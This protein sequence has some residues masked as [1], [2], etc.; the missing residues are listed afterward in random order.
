MT[1]DLTIEEFI[2]EVPSLEEEDEVEAVE[3]KTAGEVYGEKARNPDKVVVVV[4]TKKGARMALGLPKGTE[5]RDGIFVIVD[6]IAAA[7]SLKNQN[8]KMVQWIRKYGKAPHVGQKV[9]VTVNEAGF[10]DIVL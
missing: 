2:K 1:T 10:L 4:T 3:I 5:Y 8:S 6:K 7:R 9:K